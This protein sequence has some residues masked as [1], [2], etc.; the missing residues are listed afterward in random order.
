M[1]LFETIEIFRTWERTFPSTF[2]CQ[3]RVQQ[4]LI[5]RSIFPQYFTAIF[6]CLSKI[7][8]KNF[9]LLMYVK[10]QISCLSIFFQKYTAK[11]TDFFFCQNLP[12]FSL[13]SFSI[14]EIKR[15][16]DHPSPSPSN[17]NRNIGEEIKG[18]ESN[19]P[20]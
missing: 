9:F 10:F 2:F 14:P 18:I 7:K 8:K 15:R 13:F 16:S 3:N 5:F 19:L 6:S 17:S 12:S 11:I 4:F 20:I 1:N